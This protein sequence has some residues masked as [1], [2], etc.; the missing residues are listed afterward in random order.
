MYAF[1]Y[2]NRLTSITIPS[3][4]TSLGERVFNSCTGLT[5]IT[6]ESITPPTL[7]SYAFNNTDDCPIYVPYN[8]VSTY[9][10]ATGWS[11]YSSRI[12]SLEQHRT[13]SGTPY[14][15]GYDKYVDVYS[16]VSYDGGATWTTTATTPTLVEQDSE[17]C[18]WT[19][20]EV[21][22]KYYITDTTNPTPIG[23]NQYTTGFSAI[24]IDGVVQQS[25]VSA[26]TFSTTGEHTVK[27]TLTD[28]TK[29]PQN[30]YRQCY[31]L[32]ELRLPN[33]VTGTSS[34][35]CYHCTGLTT[36]V[37]PG[38]LN[39]VGAGAFSNC[40]SLSSVTIPDSVNQ[41][42]QVAFKDCSGLTSITVN[43]TYPPTIQ[44]VPSSAYFPFENT[45]NCPIYVPAES[46]ETYKSAYGWS[47]YS[48]RIQAIP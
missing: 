24:E 38:S 26:Y 46:V 48:S 21:I 37:L 31:N 3:S 28:N 2:C 33:T 41:I 6:V 29:V 16:Q 17:D 15:T 35:V 32:V 27:Y 14:C 18:G 13:T 9:K 1:Q 12:T 34:S 19:P 45:N 23:F 11:A 44:N 22:A 20:P 10:S 5:S 36:V 40:P 30:A 39:T 42:S 25:V 7:G 8:S 43:R 4:V 47:S